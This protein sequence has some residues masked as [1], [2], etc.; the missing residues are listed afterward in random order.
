M[1]HVAAKRCC[2]ASQSVEVDQ[3]AGQRPGRQER[4]GRTRLIEPSHQPCEIE[5]FDLVVAQRIRTTGIEVAHCFGDHLK[6]QRGLAPGLR[7][8]NFNHA[9][10]R[11]TTDT[12]GGV[13][14]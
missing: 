12:E 11:K 4:I 5:L 14:G 9:V 6:S 7:T 1:D 13:Q 8:V 2:V 3:C 10:A